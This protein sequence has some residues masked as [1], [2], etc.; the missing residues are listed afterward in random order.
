ML[1]ADQFKA[2]Q[3]YDA[4]DAGND[5]RVT[6]SPCLGQ[7]GCFGSCLAE[8]TLVIGAGM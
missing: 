6:S 8:S 1:P 7:C 4:G 2:L 3:A 5:I